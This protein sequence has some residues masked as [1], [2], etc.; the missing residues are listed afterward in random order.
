MMLDGGVGILRTMPPADP[1]PIAK[2]RRQAA[3][4]RARRGPR[5]SATATTCASS[6]AATRSTWRSCTPRRRCSAVPATRRSTATPP[7]DTIQSAVGAPVRARHRTAAP[8]G[9]PVRA[10]RSARRTRPG[11]P[12]PDW[13]RAALPELPKEMARSSNVAN[14]L[15]RLTLDAVEAALLA[16]RIGDEFDAVVLSAGGRSGPGSTAHGD[17]GTV[18][19]IDPAVEARLRRA[20]RAGNRRARA[21]GR[22]RHRDRDG[23]LRRCAA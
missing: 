6:T 11:T 5:T 16:P 7:E 21:A 1:T 23:A 4:P 10:G 12:V 14:R 20:P 18:Q 9:R 17:G 3:R 13:V 2:F 22:G 8:A 19:L 15:D